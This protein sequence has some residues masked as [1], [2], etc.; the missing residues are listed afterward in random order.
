MFAGGLVI[1]FVIMSY[2]FYHG[3]KE[4]VDDFKC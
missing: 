1:V 4:D 2:D 3:L